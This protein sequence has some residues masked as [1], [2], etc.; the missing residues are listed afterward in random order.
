MKMTNSVEKNGCPHLIKDCNASTIE[1]IPERVLH[2]ITI[3]FDCAGFANS[4]V[5]DHR[6]TPDT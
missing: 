1:E 2:S 6:K 4:T 5:S 3:K